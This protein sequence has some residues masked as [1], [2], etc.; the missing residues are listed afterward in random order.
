MNKGTKVKELFS[1]LR[2]LL[3]FKKNLQASRKS[4]PGIVQESLHLFYKELLR[5]WK[6]S[7]KESPDE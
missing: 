5:I 2:S 1:S 7:R 4:L 6:K 3:Q